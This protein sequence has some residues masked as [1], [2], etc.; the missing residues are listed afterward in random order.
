MCRVYW[1]GET[2]LL[3]FIQRL[4][5]LMHSD[6]YGQNASGKVARH[7]LARRTVEGNARHMYLDWKENGMHEHGAVE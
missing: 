1:S 6:Y 2:L 4:S 3:G 7:P 5:R